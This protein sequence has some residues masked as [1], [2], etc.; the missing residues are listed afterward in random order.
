MTTAGLGDDARSPDDA[1]REEYEKNFLGHGDSGGLHPERPWAVSLLHD[2]MAP[3]G[4][5]TLLDEDS[6]HM[7]G[8]GGFQTRAK[9]R[10]ALLR[11]QAKFDREHDLT[12]YGIAFFWDKVNVIGKKVTI[13]G[14]EH[15]KFGVHRAGDNYTV[16]ELSTGGM[17]AQGGYL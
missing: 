9:A 8:V 11:L 17:I 15:A 7:C 13:A 1:T 5:F 6:R 14:I 3:G 4:S 12:E 16:S 2:P 10:A